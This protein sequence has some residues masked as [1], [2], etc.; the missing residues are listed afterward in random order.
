MYSGVQEDEKRWVMIAGLFSVVSTRGLTRRLRRIATVTK[1]FAAGQY[2]QR[3]EAVAAD[4]IGQIEAHLIQV[5][6]RF[7]ESMAREKL[8]VEKNARLVEQ[9]RLSQDQQESVRQQFFERK[10]R[11]RSSDSQRWTIWTSLPMA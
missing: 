6:E 5:A 4:G 3:L 11:E 9:A 7:V 2:D 1:H 8:L 10:A